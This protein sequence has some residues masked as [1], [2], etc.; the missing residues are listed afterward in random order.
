[1]LF[2]M[3]VGIKSYHNVCLEDWFRTSQ[4][5]ISELFDSFSHQ[6]PFPIS[7]VKNLI[8]FQSPGALAVF[9][10]VGEMNTEWDW[11][12]GREV[13]DLGFTLVLQLT[14]VPFGFFELHL[15]VK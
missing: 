12:G 4:Y 1:M 7:W 10:I 8:T 5:Y 9:S 11:E 13:G 6:Y 15:S 3:V 2:G 14:W